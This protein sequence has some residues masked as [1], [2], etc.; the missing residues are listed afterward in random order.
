MTQDEKVAFYTARMVGLTPP[1]SYAGD[2]MGVTNTHILVR[3]ALRQDIAGDA[4]VDV[5]RRQKSPSNLWQGCA[6]C[7]NPCG[8]ACR[9]G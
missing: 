7:G 2:G 9:L 4:G 5:S 6:T 1:D 8:K 3:F